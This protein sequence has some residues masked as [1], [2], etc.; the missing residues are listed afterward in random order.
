MVGIYY[1]DIAVVRHR[2]APLS[3]RYVSNPSGC[4]RRPLNVFHISIPISSGRVFPET[5]RSDALAAHNIV[6]LGLRV[7]VVHIF[8]AARCFPTTDVARKPESSKNPLKRYII[9]LPNQQ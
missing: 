8:P 7:R 5:N 9:S 3:F 6:N 4:E 1:Y 2:G